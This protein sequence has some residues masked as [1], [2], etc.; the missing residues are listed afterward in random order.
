MYGDQSRASEHRSGIS[1]HAVCAL[2]VS[3]F[4]AGSLLGPPSMGC[5]AKHGPH[6][7]GLRNRSALD[8]L[9]YPL[10]ILL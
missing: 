3:S 8:P 5:I 1:S 4:A 6:R 2:V 10:C 7:A 9:H